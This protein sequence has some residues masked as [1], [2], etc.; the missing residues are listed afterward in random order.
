MS[1]ILFGD[2]LGSDAYGG[3]DYSGTWFVNSVTGHDYI[4]FVFGY[5]NNRK[6][7]L[8]LWRY[9]NYN[10]GSAAPYSAGINGMQIKV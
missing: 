8:V 5:Q 3:V 10:Y 9:E 6:F 4:G 2:S 7:Y 1:W